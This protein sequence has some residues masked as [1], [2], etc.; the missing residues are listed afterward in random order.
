MFKA[1]KDAHHRRARDRRR[2]ALAA[3][4]EA[5]YQT[6]RYFATREKQIMAEVKRLDTAELNNRVQTRKARAW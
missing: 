5:I 4:L 3:E 6:G 2:A 1:L